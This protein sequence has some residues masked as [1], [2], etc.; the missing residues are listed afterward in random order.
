MDPLTVHWTPSISITN[1]CLQ[2]NLHAGKFSIKDLL[3]Y[4]HGYTT[5]IHNNHHGLSFCLGVNETNSLISDH[6]I[7]EQATSPRP[8]F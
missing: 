8:S 2:A 3:G 5:R 6:R 4:P 1:L 7:E